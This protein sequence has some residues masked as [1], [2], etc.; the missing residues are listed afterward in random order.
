MPNNTT[1]FWDLLSKH[2]IEVP[3]I[4]RDYAQ[5][6]NNTQSLEIRKNFIQQIKEVLDK[7]NDQLHL[8][9]VYGK[10][11]GKQNVAKIAENKEAV[12]S[13][14]EA[15]KTYSRN[16]E[17]DISC[18]V[19]EPKILQ[20]ES[21]HTSFAPLDG[22]QRLTTLFLL[23]WFLMPPTD[24]HKTILK[25]F[26]YKIRPTSKDFCE[27]LVENRNML[28]HLEGSTLS[29]QIK[30]A[31]W[32]YDYWKNDPT[33]R[34]MLR[35]LNQIEITFGHADHSKYWNRLVKD[36]AV[37]F[38][39]LDLDKYKLTDEL[40][41]RMNARGVALT[42][43]EN[44]KAWLIEHIQDADIE[45][46]KIN[47]RSWVEL[48]DTTWTDLFWANKDDDNMLIDEELMRYFR[49]M[50]QIFLVQQSGLSFESDN[51]DEAVQAKVKKANQDA[52]DLA[53][54]KDSTTGEYKH[55]PNSFYTS[56]DLLSE[57]NLN[58]LFTSI[59][60]LSKEAFNIIVID[61][62]LRDEKGPVSRIGKD[63]GSL[64]KRF[65]DMDTTYRD[66]VFFYALHLFLK[67][68]SG[69][70]PQ[71]IKDALRSWMRVIRNLVENSTIDSVLAFK[72][73]ISSVSN[74]SEHALKIIDYL[75]STQIE[76]TGFDGDQ[77]KEEI[78]KAAY[79]KQDPNWEN[80][81]LKYEN[82]T[83]F[84]G[85]INFLL[86]LGEM[87]VNPMSFEAFEKNA[88]KMANIFQLKIEKQDSTKFERALLSEQEIKADKNDKGYLLDINSNYSFGT[89]NGYSSS[90]RLKVFKDAA[91]LKAVKNL[92]DK[93]SADHVEADLQKVCDD[94]Q[95]P[96]WKYQL[97][98]TP[99]AIT[100]CNQRLIRYG[101]YSNIRLLGSS[102]TNH[103]HAEL[104]SYCLDQ[105]IKK[106]I[107]KGNLNIS[108]F[109]RKDYVEV[110]SVALHAHARYT[111]KIDNVEY[112]LHLHYDNTNKIFLP[113]P[114]ELKFFIKN[115][116][117]NFENKYP[118]QV[119]ESIEDAGLSWKNEENVEGYWS[120][121]QTDDETFKVFKKVCQ[122]LN[123]VLQCT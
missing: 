2:R 42:S 119:K 36:K 83:Y 24:E 49:N 121:A 21:L 115:E 73:A 57:K 40:Y 19:K 109:I 50:M 35:M 113:N 25:K 7:E 122:A 23:H 33:V 87:E 108:P 81:F 103:Y 60:F 6:R 82:H 17:L 59:N 28:S 105:K 56:Y 1:T 76:I 93:I 44:F 61:K 110:R 46:K 98:N 123:K 47:D 10:I 27:A 51:K 94:Y 116:E 66:K 22:Q 120:S 97:I 38:E 63:R 37:S 101:D 58:E 77:K 20:D 67:K 12:K 52:R 72:R 8:N 43:F 55:L 86:E 64:F 70:K 32:F 15:V 95:E 11:H 39:F 104:Y 78:R 100:Y 84:Q 75:H 31:A 69:S 79:I 34:G 48:L 91:R 14:L 30:D 65:I 9:F 26:T 74:L 89:M 88:Q 5:G 3:I 107:D 99:K 62:I 118:Q 53:T 68:A 114:Y 29:S 80:I 112:E 16:L 71:L 111:A 45:I 4:Q 18:E 92:L 117:F 13:M 90:W 41:V 85:Q 54:V 96:G 106:E 102:A